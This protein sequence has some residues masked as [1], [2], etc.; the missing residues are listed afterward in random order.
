MYVFNLVRES[1]Y[2]TYTC[3]LYKETIDFYRLKKSAIFQEQIVIILN[4]YYMYRTIKDHPPNLN[5]RGGGLFRRRADFSQMYFASR[6]CGF[7]GR[8]TTFSIIFF[9]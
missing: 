4:S 5:G 9:L 2:L 6:R 8:D 1:R 3:L 7:S